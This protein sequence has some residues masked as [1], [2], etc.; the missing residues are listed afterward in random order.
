MEYFYVLEE[1]SDL[2]I[3]NDVENCFFEAET[4]HCPLSPWPESP[5]SVII[6]SSDEEDSDDEYAKWRA[7]IEAEQL[8]QL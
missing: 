8:P 2:S 5:Q 3:S 6:I 7:S 1:N 4:E